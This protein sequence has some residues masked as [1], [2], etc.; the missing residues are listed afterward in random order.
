VQGLP[1]HGSARLPAP[2]AAPSC[3]SLSLS[4]PP[5][6][7][8]LPA[9][10]SPSKLPCRAARAAP[11]ARPNQTVP[12]LLLPVSFLYLQLLS[13]GVQC[14]SLLASPSSTLCSS[15]QPHPPAPS[16][17]RRRPSS[18]AEP[19]PQPAEVLSMAVSPCHAPSSEF[20]CRAA[21][22]ALDPRP[23]RLLP[24]SLSSTH[25]PDARAQQSLTPP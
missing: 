11:R 5:L 2:S 7:R 21:H 4:A 22:R 9:P 17:Q 6:H 25:F 20:P 1:S 15:L 16:S 24:L 8:A 12:S 19:Q 3:L 23:P 13:H 18:P 14:F 10:S